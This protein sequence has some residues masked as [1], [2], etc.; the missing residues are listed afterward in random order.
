MSTNYKYLESF[1][2]VA[3]TNPKYPQHCETCALLDYVEFRDKPDPLAEYLRYADNLRSKDDLYPCS[4]VLHYK[5][6]S[7]G[8]KIRNKTPFKDPEWDYFIPLVLLNDEFNITLTYHISGIHL[9]HINA[10]LLTNEQ[11]FLMAND[12]LQEI[13]FLFQK[14]K[15][16][17]RRCY[18]PRTAYSRLIENDTFLIDE[19]SQD[20]LE[21]YSFISGDT[22]AENN[23][24]CKVTR[25]QNGYLA[26]V[27][28]S[29]VAVKD[30]NVNLEGVR[31]FRS[32]PYFNG[33]HLVIGSR[34]FNWHSL[35]E[36]HLCSL[37][38][39][40]NYSGRTLIF[41]D[42]RAAQYQQLSRLHRLSKELLIMS[43]RYYSDVLKR[44]VAE[45][46]VELIANQNVM[47]TPNTWTG[48]IE[49]IL[50]KFHFEINLV[51]HIELLPDNAY[52]GLTVEPD[53]TQSTDSIALTASHLEGAG[54]FV[55]EVN[56]AYENPRH[57]F[58]DIENPS[59]QIAG[60]LRNFI[61]H[62]LLNGAQK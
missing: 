48:L 14:D 12:T 41:S 57:F 44:K 10:Y 33:A 52:M 19:D 53:S 7:S 39:S 25:T 24:N 8:Y 1:A 47:N 51:D 34:L 11:L 32:I 31:Y 35:H 2:R 29:M 17:Y 20:T 26:N 58:F 18:K 13:E 21:A 54:E 28:R 9:N 5:D 50:Y 40:H 46:S 6:I 22:P 15:K 27:E 59:A 38:A 60:D 55:I 30:S 36:A 56:K 37:L 16:L 62:Y 4:V 43:G 61:K 3:I 42:D 23:S 45:S 49:L